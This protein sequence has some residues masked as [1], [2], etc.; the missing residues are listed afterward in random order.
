MGLWCYVVQNQL[1]YYFAGSPSHLHTSG[2]HTVSLAIVILF[3]HFSSLI[4]LGHKDNKRY[5]LM[6]YL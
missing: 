4:S 1:L 3:V 6:T 5:I 2:V